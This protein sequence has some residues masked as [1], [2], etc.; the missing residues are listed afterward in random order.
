MATRMRRVELDDEGTAPGDPTPSRGRRERVRHRRRAALV[1]MTGVAVVAATLLGGQ[2]VL[3]R[4]REAADAELAARYAGVPGVVAPFGEDLRVL[5]TAAPDTSATLRTGVLLGDVLVGATETDEGVELV[6][7]G[8][9]DGRRRWAVPMP[10]DATEV[11]PLQPGVAG[12]DGFVVGAQPWCAE[13]A[14]G[15]DVVCGVGLGQHVGLPPRGSVVWV[16][17]PADGTVRSTA[18]AVDGEHVLV[19]GDLLVRA[20]GTTADGGPATTDR[21]EAWQVVATDA[22]TGAPRWTWTSPSSPSTESFVEWPFEAVTA[23]G[24]ELVLRGSGADWLLSA[25]GALAGSVAPDDAHQ[26]ERARDGRLVPVTATVQGDDGLLTTEELA[27]PEVD[28]GTLEGVA[29]VL[30]S[31]FDG[32][33]LS[34]RAGDEDRWSVPEVR[35]PLAVLDGRVLVR[36][37]DGLALLDGQDGSRLWSVATGVDGDAFA[38]DGRTVLVVGGDVLRAFDLATGR[39]AWERTFGDVG[40]TGDVAGVRV[41]SGVRRLVVSRTSGEELVVG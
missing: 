13:G 1:A 28:D 20:R 16:V 36:T 33:M 14:P 31:T 21:P 3:D 24:D 39:P 5:W 40:I 37:F 41:E 8:A 12:A 35:M 10:V 17:D 7:L 32:G 18:P 6:G 34:A 9:D 22:E 19:L 25:S 38:T 27:D 11:P 26:Y 23:A 4:R 29:L 30:R 15:G 2:A